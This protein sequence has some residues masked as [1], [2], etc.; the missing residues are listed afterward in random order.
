MSSILTMTIIQQ[1]MTTQIFV[2]EKRI[3]M[4]VFVRGR[5]VSIVVQFLYWPR[6][7]KEMIPTKVLCVEI[8][9]VMCISL[10]LMLTNY[11][12]DR[13]IISINNIHIIKSYHHY[14]STNDALAYTGSASCILNKCGICSSQP[15]GR[16]KVSRW[17][18]CLRRSLVYMWS[19]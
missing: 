4:L 19:E 2:C 1:K 15:L 9:N 7:V 11:I 6:K 10:T 12:S 5:G 14:E 3:L 17:V 13:L 8:H 16:A 18:C